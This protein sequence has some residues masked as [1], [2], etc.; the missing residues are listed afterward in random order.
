MK[1][2]EA[3]VEYADGL[4]AYANEKRE[5]AEAATREAVAALRE[6][7]KWQGGVQE[8]VPDDLWNL[9]DAVLAKHPEGT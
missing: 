4:I 2:L 6:W 8:V 5:T 9:T 3:G 1:E 7:R